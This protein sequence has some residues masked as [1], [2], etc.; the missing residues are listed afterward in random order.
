MVRTNEFAE[1]HPYFRPGGAWLTP[2]GELWV[3]RSVPEGAAVVLDGFD[4]HG[5]LVRRLTVPAGR[6][7]VGM[8]RGV[9]YVVARDTDD[10]ETLE[11]YGRT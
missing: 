4:A 11:K 10:L 9:I 7:V 5:R 3:E 8:G 2:E 6:R 1:T